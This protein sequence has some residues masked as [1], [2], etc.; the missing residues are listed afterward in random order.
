MRAL[1]TISKDVQVIDYLKDFVNQRVK[2]LSH[3]RKTYLKS[4]DLNGYLEC[5]GAERELDVIYK[6]LE[7][8]EIIER[9]KEMG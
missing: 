2:V 3:F 6:Y 8:L 5:K 4:G 1:I 7:S 9:I